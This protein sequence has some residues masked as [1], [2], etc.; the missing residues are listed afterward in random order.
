MKS[1]LLTKMNFNS[2]SSEIL[3]LLII[4]ANLISGLKLFIKMTLFLHLTSK[5]ANTLNK[6]IIFLL[7]LITIKI[8]IIIT[9]IVHSIL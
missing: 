8:Q 2:K 9:K 5:S 3:K 6:M 1:N 4:F 7:F